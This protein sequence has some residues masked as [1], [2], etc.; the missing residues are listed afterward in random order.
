MSLGDLDELVLSCRTEEA[1]RYVSEAVACYKAG[2]FRACIVAAWIAVVYDLLAKIRELALGG[3]AEARQITDDVAALQPRVEAGDQ[4]AIRRSLQIER[5]I[6]H[7]AN[8]KFGFFEGP[9]V[10]D[11]QRLQDDRNRCAHTTYQGADQPYSPSAELARAHLVHAVRHVLAAP[12]VQGKAATGHI[13]RLVESNFFPTDV[14]QAKV[15]LR[16]GGL[17][18]PKA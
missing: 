10:L 6:V 15:Q 13:I 1:R 2:A 17:V 12:P 16:A 5:D 7:M 3:N 9:Q 4:N 11:L 14:D 18:R 8:D